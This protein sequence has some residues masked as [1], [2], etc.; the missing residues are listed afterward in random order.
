MLGLIVGPA[1]ASHGEGLIKVANPSNGTFT[2]IDGEGFPHPGSGLRASR[3]DVLKVKTWELK[4]NATYALWLI[5]PDAAFE[6]TTCRFANAES[7]RIMENA[8]KP[9]VN[10]T[11]MK[12]NA[13]GQLDRNLNTPTADAYKAV[14]PDDPRASAG[15]AEICAREVWPVREQTTSQHVRFTVVD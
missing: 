10:L 5:W 9:G 6:G 14:L 4:P 2:S 3:G 7:G 15:T 11:S 8:L 1:E 12:T 13:F